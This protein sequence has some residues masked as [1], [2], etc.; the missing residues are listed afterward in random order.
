MDPLELEDFIV[1]RGFTKIEQVQKEYKK[2]TYGHK[3]LDRFTVV[4]AF[5]RLGYSSDELSRYSA[6][7]GSEV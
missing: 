5:S 4:C 3:R 7:D 1:S 2:L 6:L